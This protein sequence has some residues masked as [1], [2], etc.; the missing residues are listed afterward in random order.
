MSISH[1]NFKIRMVSLGLLA[2]AVSTVI[3]TTVQAAQVIVE[4]A[5]MMGD[6]GAIPPVIA[7]GSPATLAPS[8]R[9]ASATR[10][11]LGPEPS[12]RA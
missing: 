12:A 1:S 11:T 7:T 3:A 4:A 8:T 2:F 10:L 9:R 5:A 6:G